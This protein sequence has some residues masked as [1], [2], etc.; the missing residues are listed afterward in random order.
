MAHCHRDTKLYQPVPFEGYEGH[1]SV[2]GDCGIRWTTI[3]KYLPA[4]ISELSFLD[5][6]CAE[7]Y[8]LWMALKEGAKQAVFIDNDA[9]CLEFARGLAVS[10]SFIKKCQFLDRFPS[11]PVDV[12][13]YLDTHYNGKTPELN[14]FKEF[15]DTLFISPSGDGGQN[16]PKLHRELNEVFNYVEPIYNGYENR[17]IFRCLKEK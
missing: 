16:S 14:Q 8:F 4:D 12:I 5:Y 15:C 2:R 3:R 6:G 17:T 9:N 11:E 1:G 7:G 13:F 10:N